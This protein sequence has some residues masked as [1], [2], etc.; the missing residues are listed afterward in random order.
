MPLCMPCFDPPLLV[1]EQTFQ[2]GSGAWGKAVPPGLGLLAAVSPKDM[3]SWN[4]NPMREGHV[5]RGAGNWD[6]TSPKTWNK[7]Q[8]LAS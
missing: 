2:E 7:Q 5:L 6:A 1:I 3:D 4:P 8:G